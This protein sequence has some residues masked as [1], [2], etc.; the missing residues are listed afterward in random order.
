MDI[1]KGDTVVHEG[2]EK[3][4]D[5]VLGDVLILNDKKTVTQSDVSRVPKKV[6]RKAKEEVGRVPADSEAEAANRIAL[7]NAIQ[8]LIPESPVTTVMNVMARIDESMVI[9]TRIDWDTFKRDIVR[10]A[11]ELRK[12]DP[13]VCATCGQTINEQ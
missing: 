1:Q 4:V 8:D 7:R 13:R 3:K 9:N 5:E 11:L 6:G 12:I 2:H 10:R